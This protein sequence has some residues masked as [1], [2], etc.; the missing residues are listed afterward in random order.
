MNAIRNS[1][2][3]DQNAVYNFWL[4]QHLYDRLGAYAHQR[5][6]KKAVVV[7]DAIREYLDRAE[8][9]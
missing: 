5:G 6:H 7:R 9:Q 2:D 3:R 1:S 4:A 8:K